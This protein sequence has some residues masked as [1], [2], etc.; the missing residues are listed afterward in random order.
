MNRIT[1]MIK[2][3]YIV[4][5][6]IIRQCLVVSVQTLWARGP[7][8]SFHRKILRIFKDCRG[9]NIMHVLLRWAIKH[10]FSDFGE[11]QYQWAVWPSKSRASRQPLQLKFISH[12]NGL[13]WS[14][15]PTKEST[16]AICSTR[17]FPPVKMYQF[18]LD[19]SADGVSMFFCHL[20]ESLID[21]FLQGCADICYCPSAA[22]IPWSRGKVDQNRQKIRWRKHRWGFPPDGRATPKIHNQ[23]QQEENDKPMEGQSNHQQPIKGFICLTSQH[24]FRTNPERWTCLPF[25]PYPPK[26]WDAKS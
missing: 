11:V 15:R 16:D 6:I 5:I 19:G 4:I 24:F 23:I 26:N 3:I 17:N 1:L 21:V 14:K 22:Q 12:T 20:M 9:R 25:P 2:I 10:N 13:G 18:L 8:F 7:W